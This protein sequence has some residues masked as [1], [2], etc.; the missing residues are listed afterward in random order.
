MSLAVGEKVKLLADPDASPGQEF[1]ARD[2][3]TLG[4][5]VHVPRSIW[6]PGIDTGQGQVF[7]D[8]W[9]VFPGQ[10]HCEDSG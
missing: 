9:D 3:L 6:C 5:I 8:P 10:A 1:L 2:D 7:T 4:Q